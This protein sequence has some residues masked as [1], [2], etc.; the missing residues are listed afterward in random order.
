MRLHPISLHLNRIL[1]SLLKCVLVILPVGY[2]LEFNL[3]PL[4][5]GLDLGSTPHFTNRKPKNDY[6]CIPPRVLGAAR[7][8]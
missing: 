7:A 8:A 5:L 6:V 3:Y 2:K 1:S 4:G